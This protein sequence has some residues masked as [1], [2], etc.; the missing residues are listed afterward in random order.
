MEG[1]IKCSANYIPLSPI[2]F[3]ERSAIVYRDRP[4]VVYGSIIYTW[5]ETLERCTRLASALSQLGI[6]RGD[7]VA[8]LA[9]NIPAMYELH[10]GVP[11]AG[12]V[13]C[14]LNVRHD[15]QM[16]SVLLKHSDAKFIFVDY[17]LFHVAKGAFDILSKNRT[18]VPVLVLIPESDQ[19]SP[20]FCNPIS[21]NLEYESL[22]G[23]GKLDFEIRRPKDEWDPISLNY[24]SGTTSSPKGVIYSHRGAYLNSFAAVLLNEMP[25]MPVYLWCVPMFH[26]N[27][28]C[29]TWAVAAQGGTNICQRNVTAKGIFSCISQHNVTHMGGAP[30]I[31]NMIVNA[32]ENERRPLPG[33]VI[34]MTGAAPP[35]AQ[36]LFKMEELGFNVTHAYGL[37]ETYGPGTVCSWKPEWDSLPPVEQAKIKSRQ[38][39]QHLGM[40]ELDVKDPVTMKSVPSDAKTMG[41]VMFRGNTV[42]NGYLKDH[43]AT[44]DAFKGGWFHSGDLGVKHSDGYIELKDRSKDI[45]ISGGENI[46]TIE[47]ESVLFSHPDILE[48]AIVGRPDEYWGETPCAF[49]KLKDGCK[50]GTEEIIKFCKDRLPHYM[51]PRTV[52]F[53]DLPKTSTGKVQKFVLREKAKAMGSLTKN[54][55]SKL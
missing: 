12:A 46:S 29:L 38:G 1:S 34:V 31:L 2:S 33:K 40:E 41:E 17:Q 48:A 47:V 37:T 14:T 13:L 24:T 28:W 51:A 9:P 11:M 22:L 3:L 42:M 36:V 55:I 26:C 43:Q 4:S 39:L 44:R 35:P 53:E 54:T 18:K 27:G 52:V 20:E 19:S 49:V 25:S 16:V 7:V 15:S 21:G 8:A 45:I 10:F 30:T 23:R 6:S 32:P 50:T 5:R